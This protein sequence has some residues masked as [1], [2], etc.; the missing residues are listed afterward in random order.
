M[1]AVPS[2]CDQPVTGRASLIFDRL[3]GTRASWRA[4]VIGGSAAGALEARRSRRRSLHS[5]CPVSC[6]CL[7]VEPVAGSRPMPWPD[8]PRGPIGTRYGCRRLRL[9]PVASVA[10]VP[11]NPIAVC[12]HTECSARRVRSCTARSPC[13]VVR[14]PI[15]WPVSFYCSRR[16]FGSHSHRHE[17]ALPHG[18]V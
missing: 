17:R 8:D 13:F 6:S 7:S 3:G 9:R 15:R 1:L 12:A 10:C 11:H 5:S 4:V 16:P 18:H 14:L 2:A